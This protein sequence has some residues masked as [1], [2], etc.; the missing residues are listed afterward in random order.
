M[1]M[2]TMRELGSLLMQDESGQDL[3]EY[4][5]LAGIISVA[6]IASLKGL[7]GNIASQWTALGSRLSAAL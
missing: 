7:S 4:S 5:L 3:I 1:K 2:N 6:A